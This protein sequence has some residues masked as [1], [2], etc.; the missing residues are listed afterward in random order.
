[1]WTTQSRRRFAR[2]AVNST[3]AERQ[4]NNLVVF[5]GLVRFQSPTYRLFS[6]GPRSSNP[7]LRKIGKI[8]AGWGGVPDGTAALTSWKNA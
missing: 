3:G 8:T 2:L 5:A 4:I 1:M 6:G 7:Y